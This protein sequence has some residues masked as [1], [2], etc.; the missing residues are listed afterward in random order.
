MRVTEIWRFPVK[1]M[2]G[3]TL[4]EADVGELGITGD[5][6]WSLY[7]VSTGTTLTARR[8]PDL[9]FASA[10]LVADELAIT[11]PDGSEVGEDGSSQLSSW[12]RR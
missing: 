11:L 1:S 6:G 12:L 2:G 7:D 4:L 9:L 5:R 10:R 8:A 3:E